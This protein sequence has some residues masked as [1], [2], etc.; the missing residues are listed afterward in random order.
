ME[1]RID[2]WPQGEGLDL[3]SCRTQ[4]TPGERKRLVESYWYDRFGLPK[5][6]RNRFKL[7]GKLQEKERPK[8]G[9][10]SGTL[11]P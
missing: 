4:L 11:K 1:G 10:L 9:V 6:S 8:L 3:E 2:N 7:V 5:T